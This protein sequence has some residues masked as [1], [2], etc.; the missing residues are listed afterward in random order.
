MNRTLELM[1]ELTA[2]RDREMLDGTLALVVSRLLKARGVTLASLVGEGDQQRWWIRSSC[3]QSEHGSD[4]IPQPL[5]AIEPARPDTQPDWL[6][7][8]RTQE[9]LLGADEP[10]VSLWPLSSDAVASE[11]LEL[12]TDTPLLPEDRYRLVAMLRIYRNLTV[13]LDGCERDALTGLLNRAS[14]EKAFMHATAV[15]GSDRNRSDARRD[16]R[17]PTQAVPQWLGVLDIDHF[18]RV[19]DLYGHVIGDEVLVLVAR[20]MS[21]TFRACDKLYR[22]GGEEFAVLLSAPDEPSASAALERLRQQ[23]DGYA[24]PRAG[25][26]TASIGF[27]G[28]RAGDLPQ[29]AFDRADR[30]VYH[31]KR[32]GRNQVHSFDALWAQGLLQE[33]DGAGSV[34]LFDQASEA[35]GQAH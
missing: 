10:S 32:N 24:F 31:S 5:E 19:N 17:R 21:S 20:I 1:A 15:S 14:F 25:R 33:G 8:L 11:L 6:A 9:P 3:Q 2:S 30:A 34:E 23:L 27:T 18:K 35:S 29:S 28:L 13:L 22:F 12:R 4:C 7:C 26:V 16:N